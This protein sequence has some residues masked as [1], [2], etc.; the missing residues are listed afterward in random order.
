METVDVQQLGPETARVIAAA[1]H[2][3]VLVVDSG[4]VVAVVT[5]PPA[6]RDFAIFWREREKRLAEI[7]IDPSW[8]STQAVSEDRER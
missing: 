5:K 3:D 8:D 6:P 4:R 7:T 2:G 1:Q